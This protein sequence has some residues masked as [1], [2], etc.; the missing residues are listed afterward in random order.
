MTTSRDSA[1][2]LDRLLTRIIPG[3]SAGLDPL[4]QPLAPTTSTM[5]TVWCARRDFTSRDQLNIGDGSN[6]ELTDTRIIVRAEGPAWEVND[7]FSMEGERYTVRGV[8][9]LGRSRHLELLVRG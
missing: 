2:V 6:F 8:A 9:Q 3:P 1:P 5:L 4:G 7:T